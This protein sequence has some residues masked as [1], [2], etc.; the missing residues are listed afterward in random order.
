MQAVAHDVYFLSMRLRLHE[1]PYHR[2]IPYLSSETETQAS[3]VVS[4]AG[5][6]FGRTAALHPRT[7]LRQLDMTEIG[8]Y[9]FPP[10]KL[11]H[12]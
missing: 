9:I 3:S 12:S 8:A 6:S 5:F 7:T 4:F 1:P 10:A 11:S 2:P